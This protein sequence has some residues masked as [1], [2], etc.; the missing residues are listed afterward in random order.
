MGVV[1]GSKDPND[2]VLVPKYY[3]ISSIWKYYD[4]SSIWAIKPNYLCP[5]TLRV[6]SLRILAVDEEHPS[7]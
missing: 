6:W 7:V 1:L 3:D 4:I 5:W 2:R